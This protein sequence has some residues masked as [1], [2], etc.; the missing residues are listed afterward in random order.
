MKK[1]SII[2]LLILFVSGY[3]LNAQDVPGC[4]DPL[5]N[6]YNPA[7]DVNDGSCTYNPT[8]YNPQF[9]FLLPDD[10]EET[11]A[12]IYYNGHLWTIND[13]GNDAVLY[14]VDTV[15]GS[16][17]QEITISNA[18]NIDWESLAQDENYIYIG[19][20]GNNDGNRDDL[21]IYRVSKND[22]S[23][24]GNGSV[25]AYQ[26]SFTYSD[27]TGRIEK[28]RENNFD[29][30]AF[31]SIGDSLY[32]FSKN[33]QDNRTKLYRLPK[34]LGTHVAEK[35]DSYNTSGL[36][37]GADYNTDDKE[38]TLIGYS[39]E[40]AIPFFW[41]LF[42]YHDNLVFSGNKRRIDLL[43]VTGAQTEAI[44]YTLGKHGV[45][46]NEDNLLYNQ[47]AHDLYTGNWTDET[48][49]RTGLRQAENFDFILSPNPVSGNKLTVNIR[50]LPPGD[51]QINVFD[52][53]GKL[54]QIKDYKLKTHKSELKVRLKVGH[55]KPGLYFVRMQSVNTIVEKKFIRQ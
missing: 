4:T 18:T 25:T 21:R 54:I 9:K 28:K 52:S 37:T 12:L 40:T 8:F 48:T 33:W 44:A 36:V 11:S 53:S 26:I 16:I 13:S 45:I 1:T 17:V 20:F 34:T 6:N 14:K 42:D 10:L 49:T 55:F 22:L 41:L 51:Y 29:C 35:I 23:D 30:E 24:S 7:A 19:D 15:N 31:V 39:Q 27:Y 2:I 43:N 38:I 50:Q 5:A 46:S 3:Y 32:L 47:S